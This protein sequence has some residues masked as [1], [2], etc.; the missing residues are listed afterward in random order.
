M[1]RNLSHQQDSY[2]HQP[3]ANDLHIWYICTNHE[4]LPGDLSPLEAC[5]SPQERHRY[6]SL[7]RPNSRQNFLISRGCLRYVLSFYLNC[8]P[9]ALELSLGIHGKP[10]LN[11]GGLY[12]PVQF[13]LSHTRERIA[14]ALHRDTPVGIDIE[15]LKP[16][17]HLEKLCQRCL[18][19]QESETV[20]GLAI[21][22]ATHRFLRYWT[23]KEAV[24]K[25]MG[26]GLAYPMKH[27]EVFLGPEVLANQPS[28]API[29]VAFRSESAPGMNQYWL[30]QWQ[31]EKKQHVV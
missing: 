25:A 3:G 12:P 23:A 14:I 16:L 15:R 13:N 31:P 11:P 20:L 17:T 6:N 1:T 8:P 7:Q 29:P 2:K 30:Y 10:E 27:L 26:L 28:A 24:L 19:H 21:Q 5:L 22:P 4:A 9:R 18:T